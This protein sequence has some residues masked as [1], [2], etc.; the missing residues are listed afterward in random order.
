MI[1]VTNKSYIQ[2]SGEFIVERDNMNKEQLGYTET[3]YLYK[4][5]IPEDTKS[6]PSTPFHGEWKGD[7]TNKLHLP[8]FYFHDL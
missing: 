6:R 3:I 1:L 7:N 2:Y 4:R 8:D 5:N